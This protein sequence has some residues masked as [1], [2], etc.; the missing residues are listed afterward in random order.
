MSVPAFTEAHP[1][2]LRAVASPGNSL[3]DVVEYRLIDGTNDSG[4]KEQCFPPGLLRGETWIVVMP[5][6]EYNRFVWFYWAA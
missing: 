6:D 5:V 3:V 1:N 2:D 4:V